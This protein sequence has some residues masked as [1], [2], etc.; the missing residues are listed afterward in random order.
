[1]G[2][3]PSESVTE[4]LSS[5]P[6]ERR[7]DRERGIVYGVRVVGVKSRNRRVYPPV[8]QRDAIKIYESL[9]VNWDHAK[10]GTDRPTKD[11][12][13]VIR[14]VRMEGDSTYADLHYNP[15]HERA[16]EF[17]HAVENMPEEF[18]LSHHARVLWSPTNDANGN[19][20]ALKILE[21]A[22]VDIVADGG[23]NHSI[24]ES[25]EQSMDTATIA[26][27]IT[28]ADSFKAFLSD[29]LSK[30]TLTPEDKMGVVE[31]VL[32]TL[33]PTEMPVEAAEPAANAAMES[34]RRRGGVGRWA[35]E[36]LSRVFTE[37]KAT[38]RV[39]WAKEQCTKNGLPAEFV[40]EAFVSGLTRVDDETAKSLILDRKATVASK[41]PANRNSP[42]GS[43]PAKTP[44]QMAEDAS[45]K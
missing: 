3:K 1:M 17:I 23:T 14:N 43:T 24:F 44:K 26:A 40:T 20:V 13:G 41:P 15:F 38:A 18:A 19:R 25:L 34:L 36:Q 4:S 35:A 9:P 37:R 31:E 2:M 27:G 42:A 22:S 12:F 30:L 29:L 28:D 32:S 39:Q 11:R 5:K 8:V 6:A 45:F 10:I 33:D 7:I 21:V 16:N